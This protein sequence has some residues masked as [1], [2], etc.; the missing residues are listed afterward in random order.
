MA[1]NMLLN[2]A[3]KK[4]M[5]LCAG[6]EMCYS[7]IRRKLIPLG[8][9]GDDTDKILNL[10]TRGKFIDEERYAGAFVKDKFRYNKW[11]RVKI[12][13]AL[14]MKKIPD[15]IISNALES[16]DDAEYLDLL[17]SIIGK[18]RKTVKAKNQ[19]ELKGKLLR[20]CL[21]KGFESNLIYDLLNEME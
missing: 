12:G 18:Q 16:I 21:A 3:L 15:E 20:H 13:A 11:G 19:Y 17:K 14:K 7:E 9:N 6:S 5:A 10:L 2:T 1:E 8:I 4:A